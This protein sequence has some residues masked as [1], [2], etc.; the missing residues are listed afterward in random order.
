MYSC[1]GNGSAYWEHESLDSLQ[2]CSN[3][4]DVVGYAFNSRLRQVDLCVLGQPVLSIDFV[5]NQ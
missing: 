2:N 1:W 4:L 3:S 5:S